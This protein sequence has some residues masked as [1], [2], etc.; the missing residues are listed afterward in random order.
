MGSIGRKNLISL[1]DIKE[2]TKY[3]FKKNERYKKFIIL[4][5]PIP[6]IGSELLWKIL[7]KN[8]MISVPKVVSPTMLGSL[9][10]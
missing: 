3:T 9:K 5:F 6:K 8:I 1:V 7:N 4:D 2:V 10:K